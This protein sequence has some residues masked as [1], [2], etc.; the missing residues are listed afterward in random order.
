MPDSDY[1][2]AIINNNFKTVCFMKKLIYFKTLTAIVACLALAMP[3][4]AYDFT[5]NGIYYQINSDQTSV[6]VQNDGSFNTYSGDVVIPPTVDYNGDTYTVT[7]IGYQAF[8]DCT[9]LTS[10][11]LPENVV[12]I[13][14]EA[15]MN[16]SSLTSITI[17]SSVVSMYQ[18]I[19]KGCTSLVTVNCQWPTARS[20]NTNNFDASTFAIATL[21]VPLGSK[22]SYQ[23]TTP[24]SN[25]SNIKETN[26]FMADGIYYNVT[27]TNTV[28][29]T[30]R[31]QNYNYYSGNVSIPSSVT[32]AGK[33]Y[34]VTAVGRS[35]FRSSPDLI[36]VNIP[37]TV[38][39][40][41]YGAF[42]ECSAMT[43]ISIPNSVTTLGEFC[44]M[45]CSNLAYVTL[46][47]RLTSIPRQCFTYCTSLTGITIPG[48]V[49]EISYFAFYDCES[50][51]E[52]TIEEGVEAI[53]N[54]AFERCF[55]L[56]SIMIPAS[57]T[58]I[59]DNAL[60]D[61]ISLT[62]INVNSGN[63]HYC[64]P[65]GV[66]YNAPMDSLLQYPCNKSGSVYQVPAGVKV[67]AG[68][69][70]DG[71]YHLESV[72][73]PEGL[74]TI[75][76][77]AFGN[78]DNLK[79]FT[80]PASVTYVGS[81]F[82]GG[83]P[84]VAGVDV[85]PGNQNY[86][87][88][89]GVLYTSDGKLLVQYPNGRPDK[90]YSLLNSADSIG[91]YA[92]AYSVNLKSVYIPGSIKL[93]EQDTFLSSSVERVVIDEGLERIEYSA[94]GGCSDLQNIYLPSTLNYI[95]DF[96]FQVDTK[97]KEITFAGATPPHI[98]SNAFYAVGYDYGEVDIFVPSNVVSTYQSLAWNSQMFDCNV[99]QISPLSSGNTFTVD[100]L[101][102]TVLNN[103]PNVKLSGI[104][105]N[106]LV[107]PGIS[108]KVAYQGQLY[109][110]TEM[111]DHVFANINKMIRAEVPFTVQLIDDYSFYKCVN[112]EKLIL[113]EGVKRIDGFAFSHINKLTSLYIPASV[114]S[115]M[116]DAFCYD[117][118]LQA[119]NV[120][121]ANTKYC[122]VDGILFSKDKKRLLA[123]ADGHGQTY[124]VPDGTQVIDYEAFRGATALK[125][126]VMPKSLRQI[127]HSAFFDCS[128]LTQALVPHGVTTIGYSAF[129]GCT[130]LS[131]VDLPATLTY[132]G[133][134]AF[135]N[136][137]TLWSLNVR[138]TT[139]PTC[140]VYFDSHS[141]QVAEPF[142]TD[143]YSN[144]R[145]TVPDGCAQAYRQAAVWK[146]F[147]YISETTFPV[148]FMR[149]DVNDDGRVNI[150]DVTALINYLLNGN[151]TNVNE[152]A[153][154][155]NEDNKV[156]INDV[157]S[158]INYLLSG[159]WPAPAPMDMWYLIGTNVGSSQWENDGE[160]SVGTGLIP[161]F[162][163]GEFNS[164]G[165]G[166][167]TYTGYFGATDIFFLL[168]T[169]GN[170]L[171]GW[172]L[173][174]NGNYARGSVGD[175]VS[176]FEMGNSGYYTITLDTR[177]DAL[178]ITPFDGS[179]AGVYG[180]MIIVGSHCDWNVSNQEYNMEDLNPNKENHDWLFKNFTV[181]G[182]GV[183]KFA[184][185]NNWNF[186]WG[187]D[188]FPWGRGTLNGMN[189]PVTK[190]TYDVYFND[191]TGDFNFISVN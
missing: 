189:V 141:S 134:N 50:L 22:S 114:D 162:P 187:I 38:T 95:A 150:S 67:I 2:C 16:C 172:G 160:S 74:T 129:N 135:Y 132:L 60:A 30:F 165:R 167:L 104:T 17:P 161:L 101:T 55:S 112:L 125:G 100:S 86:M 73:L 93:I 57:V 106:D 118:A 20:T 145:L 6:T 137:P 140:Q 163:V 188:Q 21:N 182:D 109:T 97:L 64:S 179:S 158:L 115:I 155:V 146:K 90:H 69:A 58:T 190:G 41:D 107:D 23:S 143:H 156:T 157:T 169:P 14:N 52:V 149:G 120:S 82:L 71:C 173:D 27:G 81:S 183:L 3:A 152:K 8:K 77:W 138:A 133:Y 119:I 94:F 63:T 43:S 19:F 37:S 174:R 59:E 91:F 136:V 184:A 127:E 121:S 148:E 1:I 164:Q 83:S 72:N 18:N 154:D 56:V 139:P 117:P 108:P 53:R 168:H 7:S 131:T 5:R 36:S 61:C 92:F 48:S 103:N 128:S 80:I 177:T 47:D 39:S 84:K 98:G 40:I 185:D 65:D 32:F 51:H 126:V 105:S 33:T 96:A 153:A 130:S 186:N 46:S 111:K 142:M 151:G 89:D 181:T 110:V 122:S 170:W 31:D 78:C 44:F 79:T 10:V 54:D 178:S 76:A 42:Y 68:R 75:G 180:A 35:A 34:T 29:V 123:F 9:D 191:I 147:T 124:T 99:S 171:D 25:F 88:D 45:R 159:N 116:N 28:E 175:V 49:K 113:R 12:Y 102:F 144:V 13:L 11:R 26:K 66:L 176:P 85:A 62:A 4:G 166:L 15:F 70:F 87:S 24:W